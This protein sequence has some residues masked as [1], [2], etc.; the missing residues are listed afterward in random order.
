MDDVCLK[1]GE[2]CSSIM[3]QGLFLDDE[4]GRK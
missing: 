4:E 3:F 1:K 2:I